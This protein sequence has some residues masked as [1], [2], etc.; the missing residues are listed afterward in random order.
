MKPGDRVIWLYSPGRSI[1]SGARVEEIPGVVERI[2]RYRIRIRVRMDGKQK[3]VSVD[4]E[5]LGQQVKN[6]RI[7]HSKFKA[8]IYIRHSNLPVF[9]G[10][11]EKLSNLV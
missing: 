5:N 3:V 2:R 7:K 11:N 8:L 1:L 6:D 4:P 10:M 9:C